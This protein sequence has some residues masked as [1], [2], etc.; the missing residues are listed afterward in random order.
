M[1]LYF[2]EIFFF[3]ILL[4]YTRLGEIRTDGSRANKN[5]TN[6]WWAAKYAYTHTGI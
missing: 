1:K 2:L 3:Y 4:E 6:N 5:S